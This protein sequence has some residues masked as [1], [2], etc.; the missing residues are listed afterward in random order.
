MKELLMA[1]QRLVI[2]RTLSGAPGYSAN[3]SILDDI[4]ASFGHHISRD[5]VRTHLNWLEEQGL[6]NLQRAGEKTLVAVITQRGTD[7]ASG[8]A[9]VEGVKRPA[10]GG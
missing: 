5:Q 10:P 9:R 3:D 8:Q 1:D 2:L 4:L 7:V 6:V